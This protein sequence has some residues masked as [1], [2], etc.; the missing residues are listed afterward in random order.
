MRGK[1]TS[2]IDTAKPV[3]KIF[4]KQNISDISFGIIISVKNRKDHRSTIKITEL[5][6]C[7]L[8]TITG[9]MY[10]QEVRIYDNVSRDVIIDILKNNLGE[11]YRILK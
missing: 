1:K 4:K 3:L 9:K 11:Q 6:G 2:V 8:L 7:H 10:K 5:S